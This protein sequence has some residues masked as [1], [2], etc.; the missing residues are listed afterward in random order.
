MKAFL[1]P[2]TV[3]YSSAENSLA[4]FIRSGEPWLMRYCWRAYVQGTSQ[5]LLRRML[6]A[7]L[8]DKNILIRHSV[9]HFGVRHPY[10]DTGKN[11]SPGQ[12]L[13]HNTRTQSAHTRGIHVMSET[14][15]YGTLTRVTRVPMFC[16][17]ISTG[18]L[19]SSYSRVVIYHARN[20]EV[21]VPPERSIER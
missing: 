20:A 13:R 7:L 19:S 1:S 16:G 8:P 3:R 15:R 5:C 14:H 17:L 21:P 12:D 18:L 2:K 9:Q 4:I 6:Q 11:R 10:R